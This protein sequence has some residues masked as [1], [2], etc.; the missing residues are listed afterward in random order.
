MTFAQLHTYEYK[1]SIEQPTDSWHKINLK[2]EMYKHLNQRLSDMRIY[3]VSKTDT[4]QV[5]FLMHSSASKKVNRDLAFELINQTKNEDGIFFTFKLEDAQLINKIHLDFIETNFDWKIQLDASNDQKEWYTLLDDYRITSIKNKQVTYQY[6]QLHFE[7]SEYQ[8]YRVLVKNIDKAELDRARLRRFEVEK[9]EN[10]SYPSTITKKETTN[11]NES[12]VFAEMDNT[13]RIS[14]V[15][16]NIKSN[17]DYYRPFKLEYLADSVKLDDGYRY[18]YATLVTG[19]LDS[20][21]DNTYTFPATT[22]KKMRL[23]IY[24][25][26]N[27]PLHVDSFNVSGFRDYLLARFT[28]EADF[29]LVYG[30]ENDQLPSYD[31]EK[32]KD[33]IPEELTS[34]SLGEEILIIPNQPMVEEKGLFENKLWLWILMILAI[35]IMGGFTLKMLRSES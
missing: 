11:S 22:C 24:N 14:R 9:G 18:Q 31:I 13:A 5:P 33:N 8:Y 27:E 29:F 32:F 16:I 12:L 21:S 26:N 1:R 10:I 19:V 35:V 4:T 17:F 30:K 7:S 2:P 28:K 23:N 3:G 20:S 15:L 6:S 25:G 34:L